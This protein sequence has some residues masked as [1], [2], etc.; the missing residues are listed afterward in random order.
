M[1]LVLV[2][3]QA[4]GVQRHS[5]ELFTVCTTLLV[6]TYQIGLQSSAIQYKP[7]SL[8]ASSRL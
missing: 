5:V 3:T 7:H 8:G 2:Q 4:R 1:L 6:L